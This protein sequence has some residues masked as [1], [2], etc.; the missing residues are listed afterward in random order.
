MN[1]HLSKL[2]SVTLVLALM[3]SMLSV[4]GTAEAAPDFFANSTT[5]VFINEIHYDNTGTDAGE[6]I[7]IAGPAGTD[8]TGWSII[9]YNGNG[10]AVYNTTALSG[11]IAD[12]SGGYGTVV[13]NYPSN[14]IQNGSPDGIAL[15]NGGTLVQF[16]SYEGSFNGVGGPADGVASTDI[17]VEE[18]FDSAVGDSLQLVGSGTTYGDF[19]WAGSS[20]NTFGAPNTGQTF[21]GAPTA[22]ALVI[23]EIDYDQPST[24]TAEFVEI[25]NNDSVSVDLSAYSLVFVNGNGVAAYDTISLPATSLA[26]GD[27]FVV[28]ANTATVANCDLDD[29]PDTNF[30]QNGA[31]D[32]VALYFGSTLIDVVSYEG[33]TA[34]PFT[35]GSGAG[36]VDNA[37]SATE[38]ISRCPDGSDTNQNNVDFSLREITP[39]AANAC[40]GGALEPVIN[41]FS[42]STTGTDVEYVEIFGS[43]NTDYS[44]Y[45]VLELEG[46]SSSNTGT[47]D[48]VISLGTT[49]ADGFYLA[50]LPA[51]ALENGS[52]S[53]L[54]VK[55]FTGAL[56]NDLDTNDDGAFD[57]TPW[58]AVV[59]AVSVN[60][61]GSGDLTYGVP[62][63][64][65]NYDGVSTF[66]PGGASR[67]PDGFDTD[68][69]T[70]WVR[71]DF[72]LAGISGYSGSISLGEAYN[73]PGAANEVYVAPPEMCGDPFTPIYNVQGNG[74]ASPLVGTEVSI[75]GVV[76]GDFQNNASVDNGD[77]NGFHV[78][79]PVGDGDVATSDGIFVFAPGGMD[80]AVGDAVRVRGSV[81]EYFGLTEI[82]A[83][84][85][86]NCGTGSVVATELSLPVSSVD[87]FEPYEGML[88]TFPQPLVISEY[89]NFDRFGEIVLTST[90]HLTPTAEFEPGSPEQ[91]QA[92]QN[93]LLDKITLDDGRTNQNPDPAIHPNGLDFGLSNLFRGGD[94]VAN[95]TG[96]MDYA[97]SL[98]RIQPTQGANHT[99]TNVR[100]ASPDDVSGNLKVASFNVLNYFTTLDNGGC[101]YA[102]GC[103]GADNADEFTRQRDKIIAALAEIDADVVGL[104]EI[105]N[106]PS[107]VSTADLVSGLNAVVGADTYAYVSTGAIGTD[108]IK[109][110]LIYKPASVSLVGNYAILDS[111][112]DPRF[113]DDK[114][115]PTLAQTFVNYSTG[116]VF[117]VA[118]NH[119]K[120]KGS[121]CN[122]VGDPDLG[123][124]AGNCNLTRKAAAEAMVD[125]LASDP[126]GSGD[127]DFLIIGDLNSYDKEEPIDVLVAGGFTDM[128]Y[129]YHGEGAYSYVFDGQIGYLDYALASA[130][131]VGEATGVTEWHI[132][133]DEPDLIDYDTS[134]KGPNQD[135]I[136]APDAYRS[137][138]HDPVIVGLE[139]TTEAEIR[140]LIDDVQKLV[141]DGV[142][143]GGQGNALF[144]KLEHALEKLEAGKP[145]VA[146]NQLGAFINQVED[147]VSEGVLTAEQGDVFIN[148]ATFLVEA[149]D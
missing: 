59:D 141:D 122:D 1:K 143:N 2:F 49:D 125:W 72:D 51:N 115:R 37:A 39:G 19:T 99:N 46:D 104:L 11:V 120:S 66:A 52:I 144:V 86:W 5:T 69:A 95:V 88:V 47:V 27:Y 119:L 140:E 28:C 62:A 57:A 15:V 78:Q 63:L 41:E 87:D 142:L 26:A 61:G 32:A 139:L 138:D 136:Y 18:A 68:A 8:L 12:Q 135:A 130:D 102:G 45:T 131:L 105:E 91:Q 80:V 67:L 53:L 129:A 96:V 56:G 50:S 48:E 106:H 110:A 70:D 124:G 103:R 38:G 79:D 54:L 114:N 147:F 85:I 42:A 93:Y 35:E 64:G 121:A 23:N 4:A 133:A 25:R 3:M 65:P 55:N 145:G 22:K 71:N 128:I 81:S 34:A 113:N 29:G 33:D 94:T 108:A 17:G 16:L 36:L 137:S 148:A 31:P 83:S 89:F 24:D 6:A 30:I 92:V 21:G 134:F 13:V 112:V 98:Y 117:T 77:L 116:G 10:G 73:T 14:G 90:R 7:E 40:G 123:D 118:V 111:I 82:T 132:N 74:A 9:L 109:V 60:D 101:P 97:F 149:L 58:D 75:E 84:Q 107:D 44:A 76:V 100:T 43:P 146:A 127:D 20:A 126:T